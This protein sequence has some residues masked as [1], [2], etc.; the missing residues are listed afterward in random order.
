MMKKILT[1]ACFFLLMFAGTA[2]AVTIGDTVEVSI[3]TDDGN[4]L[5]LYAH[6]IQ[7]ALKKVYAEA[8]KGDYYRIIIRNKLNRRIGVVVAV[9]GRNI[10]SGKKS[11]LKSDER[12]YILEPYATGEYAGWRTAQDKI[13][14]F[15]FTD[16]A[17]SYAAAFGDES[18]MGVI[19]VA[20]YPE[21][22]YEPCRDFSCWLSGKSERKIQKDG[23]A[24]PAMQPRAYESAGTGYGREEY[25]PSYQVAFNPEK[26][27]AESILIKYEWRKTLCDLKIINCC[28]PPR[29]SHNRIWD[30]DGFAPP[31]P[32]RR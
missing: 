4:Y 28:E 8:V 26:K 11:W 21:T 25:S 19:A 18:A 16:V 15:Y 23:A 20:V 27:K 29:Y 14:R 9:D 7:P 22:Q 12:M 5:P 10:I 31:P 24:A 32:C 13:N 30:N 1:T 6:K 17:D 3:L 2:A